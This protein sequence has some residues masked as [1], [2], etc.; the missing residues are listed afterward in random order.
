MSSPST[1]TSAARLLYYLSITCARHTIDIANPYFVPDQVAIDA[2][3]AAHRRG[4]RIRIMVAGR[5]H[6]NW[7]ARQNSVRLYG[8]LLDA[9]VELYEFA[10]TMLHQKTMTVDG[11]WATI[12]TTNFDARSFSFNQESNVSFVDSATIASLD[13][14]F[15]V[16]LSACERVT[17]ASWQQRGWWSHLMELGASVLQEQA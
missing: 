7:L 15:E 11:Q 12:G 13:R 9:G 17:R 2:F 3:R 5:H 4:V 16:D 14:T 1:G 6:D 8:S 10:R